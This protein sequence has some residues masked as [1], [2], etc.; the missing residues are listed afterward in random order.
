MN[1]FKNSN[2]VPETGIIS[3]S[4][5]HNSDI[6]HYSNNEELPVQLTAKEAHNLKLIEHGFQLG[7]QIVDAWIENKR[8]N[9]NI[10]S[11]KI[12]TS[13]ALKMHAQTIQLMEKT[14]IAT[15]GERNMALQKEY[16][17]LDYGMQSGDR[18]IILGALK[19]I[20]DIVVKSPLEDVAKIAMELR[21]TKKPLLLDF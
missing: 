4:Q 8:I 19:G 5:T 1:F 15:F 2:D 3:A 11:L 16:Q 21:D 6:A 18:D 14:I 12:A 7:S 17:A 10:K 20:S 9:G 13:S